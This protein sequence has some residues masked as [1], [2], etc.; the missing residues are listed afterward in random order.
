[1]AK[2]SQGWLAKLTGRANTTAGDYCMAIISELT[3][4]YIGQCID[5]L[6]SDDMYTMNFMAI[7]NVHRH[8]TAPSNLVHASMYDADFGSGFQAFSTVHPQLGPGPSIF[9]YSPPPSTG[10]LVTVYLAPREMENVLK[11]RFWM[12]LAEH[13]Y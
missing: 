8:M 6:E 3:L 2:E 10:I 4:P 7:G 9:L 5:M 11:S 13:V 12:G 1:M